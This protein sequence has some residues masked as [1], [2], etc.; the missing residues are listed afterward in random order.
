MV[1]TGR[2]SHDVAQVLLTLHTAQNLH[3]VSCIVV[4]PGPVIKDMA[5]VISRVPGLLLPGV[6]ANT[7][8]AIAVIAPSVDMAFRIQSHG[9]PVTGGDIDDILQIAYA[10]HTTNLNGGILIVLRIVQR[11]HAAI[12]NGGYRISGID[13]VTQLGPAVVAPGPDGAVCLQGNR[14]ASLAVN[15]VGAVSHLGSGQSGR[16][17][18]HL[19]HYLH[20]EDPAGVSGN[21]TNQNGSNTEG[22]HHRLN[23]QTVG[24]CIVLHRHNRGVGRE[25][26]KV[27]NGQI[28]NGLIISHGGISA[29]NP[30]GPDP[31]VKAGDQEPLD[32]TG[33]IR[34]GQ[35]DLQGLPGDLGD[36]GTISV[37][38]PGTAL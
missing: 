9:K 8:A 15:I 1:S 11:C 26:L 2:D 36:T 22:T 16:K 4:V 5:I 28:M 23:I 13:P 6:G 3:G 29:L 24:I 14:E 20:P 38:G 12:I 18:I 27:G 34:L 7:Q 31:G 21:V 32:G 35:V 17:T 19:G 33:G 25:I 37:T 30:I 10:I